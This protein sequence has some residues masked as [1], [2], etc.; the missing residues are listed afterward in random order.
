MNY[1]TNFKVN[2][3]T[4]FGANSMHI[5]LIN[6]Y[7]FVKFISVVYFSRNLKTNNWAVFIIQYLLCLVLMC[8]EIGPLGIRSQNHLLYAF[9]FLFCLKK[10]RVSS[11]SSLKT[12]KMFNLMKLVGLDSVQQF[13]IKRW[14]TVISLLQARK[15]L[16]WSMSLYKIYAM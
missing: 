3:K 11:P 10:N 5:I 2:Y 6:E 7:T 12:V 13:F 16:H 15:C 14:G 9:V 4:F 1:Q 8:R